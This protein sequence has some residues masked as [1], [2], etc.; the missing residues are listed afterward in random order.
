MKGIMILYKAKKP[1]RKKK[2]KKEIFKMNLCIFNQECK[3]KTVYKYPLWTHSIQHCPC[4]CNLL[5]VLLTSI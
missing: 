2:E 1:G 4:M 3:Q 5:E